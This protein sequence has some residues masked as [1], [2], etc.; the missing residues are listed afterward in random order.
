MLDFVGGR[1]DL[2]AGMIRAIGDPEHRFT[3]DKLRMLRAIRFAARFEY[4]IEPGTFAAIQRVG[5]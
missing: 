1:A 4:G 5:G 3:E 2:K